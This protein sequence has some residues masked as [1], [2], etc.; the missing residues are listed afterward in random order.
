MFS[1]EASTTSGYWVMLTMCAPT[2]RNQ[3]DSARV[4]NR[5]PWITTTVPDGA[6]SS[7]RPARAATAVRRRIGSNGSAAAR[8]A[9]L[10]R[11]K[12]VSARPDVR[13]M[14]WSVTTS[15]PGGY[16]GLTPPTAEDEMMAVTPSEA[17][18]QMFAR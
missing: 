10:P 15:R 18:A 17:S 14:N 6:K 11:S 7:S 1:S 9:T 3:S 5:G 12:K 4:E 16:S 8:C 2:A 13:S